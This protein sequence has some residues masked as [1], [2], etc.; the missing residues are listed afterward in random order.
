M[1]LGR[2][3][4][5]CGWGDPH[6]LCIITRFHFEV[7]AFPQSTATITSKA[8]M[9][10]QQNQTQLCLSASPF[11]HPR[12]TAGTGWLDSP[13][14]EGCR[15]YRGRND[16]FRHHSYVLEEIPD[17][18]AHILIELIRIFQ[19]LH[20]FQF[21]FRFLQSLPRNLVLFHLQPKVVQWCGYNIIFIGRGDSLW[22][23]GLEL[24]DSYFFKTRHKSW[25]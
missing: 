23:E 25:S 5:W 21:H 24:S 19:T 12:H 7:F 20:N 16:L 1:S 3:E 2:A 17:P 22:V 13:V 6:P 4:R 8:F 14:P 18:D 15:Y 10:T 11:F 9:W